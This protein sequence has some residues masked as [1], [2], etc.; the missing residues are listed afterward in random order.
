MSFDYASNCISY[1]G[2]QYFRRSYLSVDRYYCTETSGTSF[3]ESTDGNQAFIGDGIG[4]NSMEVDDY[5][6]WKNAHCAVVRRTVEG[7]E[8]L[9][10]FFGLRNVL[11]LECSHSLGQFLL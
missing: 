3:S 10:Y 9:E 6:G 8:C 5:K 11:M 4:K 1:C 2:D 7:N